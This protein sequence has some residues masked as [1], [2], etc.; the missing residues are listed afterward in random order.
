MT[1]FQSVVVKVARSF[2]GVEG[3]YENSLGFYLSHRV[4][5]IFCNFGFNDSPGDSTVVKFGCCF[6][7]SILFY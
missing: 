6:F 1:F 3:I 2:A 7:Y 5:V 4:L